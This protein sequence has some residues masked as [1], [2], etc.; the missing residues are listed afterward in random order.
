MHLKLP[1][2]PVQIKHA[3]LFKLVFAFVIF[4]NHAHGQAGNPLMF[5]KNYGGTNGENAACIVATP[6]GGNLICGTTNSN[7]IDV[8]GLHGTENDIWLVKIS[9]TGAIQWQKTYDST[10]AEDAKYIVPTTDGGYAIAGV[11]KQFTSTADPIVIRI[12]SLGNVLW[13]KKF[14]GS[15]ADR[16]YQI[17]QSA[18]G[19]FLVTGE[20]IGNPELDFAGLTNHG[21]YD[22]FI[23]K[24]SSTGT[25]L[26]SK[27]F[28]GT[29][30]ERGNFVKQLSDGNIL[31]GARAVSDNGDVVGNHNN[32]D[33]GDFW[34][35]K[36]D[37]SGNVI[38]KK[39]YGGDGDETPYNAIEKNNRYYL[40]GTTMN[41][42][43]AA[44][45]DVSG[46]IDA[47]D[48]WFLVLDTAGGIVRQKCIGGTS[49]VD[50]G[51]DI[52]A[53]SDGKFMI[54]G[55]TQ[56]NDVYVSGNHG[57]TDMAMIKIDSMGNLKWSKLFGST[58]Y[59]RS[60]TIAANADSSFSLPGDVSTANGDI[61]TIYGS[62]DIWLAR[63]KDTSLY[64]DLYAKLSGSAQVFV[65]NRINYKL[66]FG[67]NT[68]AI[69]GDTV[70]L[71][72]IR[73]SRMQLISGTR[74]I[75]GISGD[76]IFWKIHR[77]S[78]LP[79]DS[80]TL[81]FSLDPTLAFSPDSVM[82]RA[83]FG[84]FNTEFFKNDNIDSLKS[85]IRYQNSA[86]S[87]PF[88]DIASVAT[89]TSAK[90]VNYS[91]QYIFQSLLDTTKGTI[92]VVKDHKTDFISAIPSI[93]GIQ[94]DTLTWNFFTAN[95]SINSFIS[96]KL[97]IKDPPVVQLGDV[98][99][100]FATLQF[101]TIDTQ[102][103]KRTDS[104][105][106]LVNAICSSP[107]M[108]NTTL[109]PPQG[110]QWLRTF[111]GSGTDETDC[112]VPVS[113][114]SFVAVISSDSHDG[115]A[116]GSPPDYNGFAVKYFTDGTM[117]W[118]KQIG[119]NGTDYFYSGASS[120]NGSVI[121]AGE[122]NSVDGGFSAN[123][124]STDVLL[125]KL[126]SSGNMVWQKLLGG[127]RYEGYP[128]IQKITN[129]KY[130]ILASTSSINGDVANPYTDSLM[131]YTWLFAINGNGNMLW[132]KVYPDTL[133]TDFMDIQV[134]PG[135]GYILG[136]NKYVMDSN[137]LYLGR[138]RLIKTDSLGNIQFLKDFTNPHHSQSIGAIVANADSTFTFAGYTDQII[139]SSSDSTCIGDH[140]Q[141]DAW[142]MK[143]D[144]NGNPIWQKYY[145]STGYEDAIHI[146]RTA[147]GGYLVT[148]N[149]TVNNGNVTNV[150]PGTGNPFDLWLFK[151]DE[152]G[153]LLWQKAIGG[154]MEEDGYQ[155]MQMPN[156]D[157]FVAG[158]AASFNNGD[159]FDSRGDYDGIIVKIGASNYIRGFVFSDNNGN[160][161]KDVGESYFTEGIVKSTRGALI[162]SG[163]IV[164]GFYA[165]NVDTGTYITKPVVNALY[166]TPYPAADTVNFTGYLQSDTA[167]FAMVPIPNINDLKVTLLP[168]TA[169]R[170]GF[171][172]QYKIRYENVGTT[173]IS[174][175]QLNMVKDH[176]CTADSASPAYTSLVA[177]TLRWNFNNLAPMGVKE[178]TVYL[179]LQL[180]PAV[181]NGDTLHHRVTV[182]PMAGDS[183]PLNNTMAINQLVTG[184]FDPNDKTETH[185]P[186]FPAQALAN[187]EYLNYIIR[188]QNTG[189]DTA[190]RVV[191]RDTLDAKLDWNSVEMIGA[192]HPYSFTIT[193]QNKMDWKFAPIL[194]PDSIH[195]LAGSHGY[196]AYR[197][198]PLAGLVSGDTIT[199]R[200]AIYFD[201]NL[202]VVTNNQ[203]TIIDN[204]LSICPGANTL[205]RSGI[206][207]GLSYQWQVNTGNGYTNIS[208]NGIYSGVNTDSIGITAAPTSYAGYKYRCLVNTAGGG[209]NSA[210]YLLAFSTQWTGVAGS[211]WENPA[212]WSCGILPDANTDVIINAGNVLVNLGHTIRSLRMRPGVQFLINAGA[213][214]TIN[215]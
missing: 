62:G 47:Y 98:L 121:L 145:G 94:G 132:Q 138:G 13:R 22:L 161:I 158:D 44:S 124:G 209:V 17:A 122:T 180:P 157:I 205:F 139:L 59:D 52:V 85:K 146:L 9:K 1:I 83:S 66:N 194:L 49:S 203:H 91:I 107:N 130:I 64:Q 6:D 189:T 69:S 50:Y 183:T 162:R 88:I 39:C 96:L 196:L 84:P 31:V 103:L 200:A 141:A 129:D 7:N 111:G 86:I 178:I 120:S 165:N 51:Q 81:K 70:T 74:P 43:H 135:N 182:N 2:I 28:G 63:Y 179:K 214:F 152:Q 175:G 171:G 27:I 210:E 53:T 37:P 8:S 215:H 211:N 16:A 19:G 153:N 42:S 212:N 61:Q 163:D 105:S 30:S 32:Y 75:S 101:S 18:D 149:A 192:S 60:Y 21:G 109:P 140:G 15:S 106:Q 126:D 3:F 58:N 72:F 164:N 128:K 55:Y 166:Y 76:T 127:S 10:Y 24:L 206:P 71:Q 97:Q 20:T 115:D 197:V 137:F 173:T 176:R 184:S 112:L 41:L 14:G 177:D 191:I 38:W 79:K 48:M 73:D 155:A 172:A 102:S 29:Q 92:K 26:W 147:G 99:K 78:V 168:L 134:T 123:H 89:V 65:N 40:I 198:K 67:R 156:N 201:F 169:A 204:G 167:N 186:G 5:S 154:N 33:S 113:D 207:G 80:L 93:T 68:G 104:V 131:Q 57:L 213:V 190:F 46:V 195:S 36:L 193:D 159:I 188:F 142:I 185:G 87:N 143:T 23:S 118:K 148:G 119:G 144:K 202:P 35:L 133:I 174:S 82:A 187:G 114:S 110:I 136:G 208:N 125:T 90:Q 150:H 56:S 77:A 160:H 45:G 151:L 54:A 11:A 117:A 116:T 4:A 108:V 25:L 34:I 100:T 95:S 199:N 181:N 170:P 12:D